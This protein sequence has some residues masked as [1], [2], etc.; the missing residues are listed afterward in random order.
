MPTLDVFISDTRNG[1]SSCFKCQAKI[2]STQ[3]NRKSV[4]TVPVYFRSPTDM[5]QDKDKEMFRILILHSAQHSQNLVTSILTKIYH[6]HFQE[7]E[8][9]ENVLNNKNAFHNNA[10]HPHIDQ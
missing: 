10:Y 7:H 6:I 3:K 4:R 1:F 5:T 9:S 8:D 2:L